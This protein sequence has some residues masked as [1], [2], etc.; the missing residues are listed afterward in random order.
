MRS[1]F[2]GRNRFAKVDRPTAAAAGV[3]APTSRFNHSRR[4]NTSLILSHAPLQLRPEMPELVPIHP[5]NDTAINMDTQAHPLPS[6][7]LASPFANQ[8]PNSLVTSACRPTPT[9][10]IAASHPQSSRER[11]RTCFSALRKQGPSLR[12]QPPPSCR[13]WAPST[14]ICSCQ[15]ARAGAPPPWK[16]LRGLQRPRWPRRK[17]ALRPAAC[18]R[19]RMG[20][21]PCR[22]RLHA[23]RYA[24]DVHGRLSGLKTRILRSGARLQAFGCMAA[25][26][27]TAIARRHDR[28]R[29][30]HSLGRCRT[31]PCLPCYNQR[32]A[33]SALAGKG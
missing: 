7:C 2:A 15:K 29:P 18:R 32:T 24:Y 19:A 26:R 13:W 10:Q 33:R 12:D 17:S 6:S 23:G 11:G 20:C 28:R 9:R 3:L 27:H 21:D 31:R 25:M 16:R 30:R 8:L 5:P 22:W 1:D 4:G 14:A